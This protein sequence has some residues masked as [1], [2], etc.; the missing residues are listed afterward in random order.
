MEIVEPEIL[1]LE[2][3]ISSLTRDTQSVPPKGAV[4]FPEAVSSR[5]PVPRR[6]HHNG[7][8]VDD[9]APPPEPPADYGCK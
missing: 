2:A 8:P 3:V 5:P 6:A 7:F 1:Q 4:V 9:I